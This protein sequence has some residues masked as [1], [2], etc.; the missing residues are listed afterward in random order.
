M[1]TPRTHGSIDIDGLA[2]FYE[3]EGDG[4][5]IVLL[6]GGLADSSTWAAQFSGFSPAR[7][8]VAPERQAQ[9]HTCARSVS[10]CTDGEAGPLQPPGARF[11][12]EPVSRDDDAAETE[13]KRVAHP[14]SPTLTKPRC[15][16][17][18]IPGDP[19]TYS[20]GSSPPAYGWSI[21]YFQV[22]SG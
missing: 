7:H 12:G 21:T 5:T 8:V 4:E 18:R 11:H 19:M 2:V 17:R 14:T 6:H 1:V 22:P 16:I 15:R 3:S 10:P 20:L 9:G 13:G